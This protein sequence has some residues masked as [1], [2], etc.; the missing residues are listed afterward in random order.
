MTALSARK[1]AAS[2][3]Q[4][5]CVTPSSRRHKRLKQE[6]SSLEV[7]DTPKAVEAIISGAPKDSSR[8]T[9][10]RFIGDQHG[11]LPRFPDLANTAA[12][13]GKPNLLPRPMTL[14]PRLS[15]ITGATVP[16]RL[17]PVLYNRRPPTLFQKQ[18]EEDAGRTVPLFTRIIVPQTLPT[19][20]RF[21]L[22]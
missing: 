4:L 5:Q 18:L 22:M 11:F 1:R 7:H 21:D 16:P 17:C 12:T 8:K 9:G 2:Q 20:D 15:R 6:E 14:Q 19:L 3:G 13:G 10:A